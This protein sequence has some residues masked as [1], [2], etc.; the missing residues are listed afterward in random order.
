MKSLSTIF[1]IST[2]FAA[3]TFAGDLCQE[4]AKAMGYRGAIDVLPPCKHQENIV[5]QKPDS[6][7]SRK[8]TEQDFVKAQEGES[9]GQFGQAQTHWSRRS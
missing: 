4:E 9:L 2:F 6:K 8:D 3:P 1:L 5:S 7:E